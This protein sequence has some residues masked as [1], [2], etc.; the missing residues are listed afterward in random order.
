MCFDTSTTI[1][2]KLWDKFVEAIEK[3]ILSFVHD[4]SLELLIQTK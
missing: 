2:L 3:A 1:N 4:M